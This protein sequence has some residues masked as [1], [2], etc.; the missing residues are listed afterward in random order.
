MSNGP[1]EGSSE[2]NDYMQSDPFHDGH[3]GLVIVD[4][5]NLLESLSNQEGLEMGLGRMKT[6][7]DQ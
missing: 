5:D 7:F 6:R 4:A 1:I 2:C 3:K